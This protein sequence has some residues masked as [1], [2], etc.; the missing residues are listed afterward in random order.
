MILIRIYFGYE[1][2]LKFM[3]GSF[4]FLHQIY[5]R[6]EFGMCEEAYDLEARAALKPDL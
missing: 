2:S 6:R 5:D 1:W 4:V 3:G